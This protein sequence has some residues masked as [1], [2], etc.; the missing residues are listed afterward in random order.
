MSFKKLSRKARRKLVDSLVKPFRITDGKGF[1]LSQVK[2]GDTR[3]IK[4]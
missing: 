3:G 1:R 2:P 4:S